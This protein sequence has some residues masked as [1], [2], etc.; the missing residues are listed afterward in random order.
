[1]PASVRLASDLPQGRGVDRVTPGPF[2][3]LV[4]LVAVRGTPIPSQVLE[5]IWLPG[6]LFFFFFFDVDQF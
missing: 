2:P 1:M 5:A 6:L 4:G 3:Y